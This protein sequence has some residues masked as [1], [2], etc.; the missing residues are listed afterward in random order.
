VTLTTQKYFIQAFLSV[1]GI[2]TCILYKSGI[3]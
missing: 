3:N 2:E 1:T